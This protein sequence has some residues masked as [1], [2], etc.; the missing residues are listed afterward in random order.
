MHFAIHKPGSPKL[1]ACLCCSDVG[2]SFCT[3]NPR[4]HVCVVSAQCGLRISRL[5]PARLHYMPSDHRMSSDGSTEAQT[6]TEGAHAERSRFTQISAWTGGLIGFAALAGGDDIFDAHA[7]AWHHMRHSLHFNLM[8]Y[9]PGN[10]LLGYAGAFLTGSS[11]WAA[12]AKALR[13]EGVDPKLRLQ[14]L[15]VAV[16]LAGEHFT[17]CG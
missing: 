13:E 3:F 14:A 7:A 15:P 5:V 10:N 1:T 2:C 8:L 4:Q 17:G 12:S 11:H 16:S 6:S 9:R